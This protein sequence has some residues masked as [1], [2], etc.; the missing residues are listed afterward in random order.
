MTDAGSSGTTGKCA[1]ESEPNDDADT[2][3]VLAPTLCGTLSKAD[4]KDFLTFRLK[5][6]T[7]TVKINFDGRVQLLVS[8]PGHDSVKLTPDSVGVIPFEKDV[9]YIIEVTSLSDSNA[10]VPWRVE[11]VE[12]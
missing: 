2:A 6:A 8:V 10:E 3:N 5:A 11:V 4:Q 7:Q 9:D 1:Q 12:T